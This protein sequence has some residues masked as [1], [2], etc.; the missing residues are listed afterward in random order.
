MVSDLVRQPAQQSRKVIGGCG[1]RATLRRKCEGCCKGSCFGCCCRTVV[2]MG[3]HKV[4][5]N[6]PIAMVAVEIR[7]SGTD[8]M[9]EAGYEAIRQRLR[10]RWPIQLPAQDIAVDF[11]GTGPSPI[12]IEYRRF[13]TRDKRTAIVIRPGATTV[14]TVDY[15]GWDDLRLTLRAALDARAEVSEPSGYER[16]GLR[17]IDEVRVPDDEGVA[18][19]GA[20]VHH[21]LLGAQP[22]NYADLQ[23]SNW[24]GMSTFG[25]TDGKTLV[26]RYGPRTGFAVDPDGS[27]KRP[28]SPAGPFFLLD[29]D[30]FWALSDSIPEFDP[31]ELMDRCDKLHAPI[32]EL[33][34]G[35]ITDKLRKEVLDA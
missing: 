35:L 31:G 33:F 5:R 17:Y 16:V 11:G 14:E 30:N 26:L 25:P 4:Y 34:E 21:S 13:A 2:A 15:K 27:L 8:P 9:T 23:P 3:D 29:I 22:D 1:F 18:N 28:N 10:E 24:Q 19:W 20:W 32:R 6:P 7:H 12:V